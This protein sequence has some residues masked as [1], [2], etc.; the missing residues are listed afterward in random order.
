MGQ[1]QLAPLIVEDLQPFWP[2][3]PIYADVVVTTQR[4]ANM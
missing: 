4:K 1:T 3:Q 2:I